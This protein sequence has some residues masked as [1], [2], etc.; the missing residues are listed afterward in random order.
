M[1]VRTISPG[2][3]EVVEDFE[4][5]EFAKES[6]AKTNAELVSEREMVSDFL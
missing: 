1:P 2:E 6:I 5:N 3:Y 4:H